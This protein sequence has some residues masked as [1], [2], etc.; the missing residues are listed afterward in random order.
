MKFKRNIPVIVLV[1]LSAIFICNTSFKI[2]KNEKYGKL[3]YATKFL[4]ADG[5]WF[6]VRV[7]INEKDNVYEINGTSNKLASGTRAQF[8]KAIW[9]GVARRQLAIGP[10]ETQQEAMNAK[11]IYKKKKEDITEIPVSQYPSEVFWFLMTFRQLVRTPAYQFER[12]PARVVTGTVDEFKDALFEGITFQ[13]LVIGPF[14]DYN[15]AE[16]A[17]SMYR[18]NE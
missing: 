11:I 14:W 6:F 16:Q 1:L 18:K 3:K 15:V 7:Q 17:K 10:F 9:W 13:N 5:W 12:M 2:N 8:E 4:D